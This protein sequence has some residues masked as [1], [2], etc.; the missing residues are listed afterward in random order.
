MLAAE[1]GLADAVSLLLDAGA[2]V[3]RRSADGR[4]A[5]AAAEAIGSAETASLLRKAGARD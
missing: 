4:T 3:N 2:D 1:R 5:L